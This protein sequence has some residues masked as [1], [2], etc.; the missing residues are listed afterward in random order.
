S[1]PNATGCV[2]LLLSGL[3]ADNRKY[4]PYMIKNALVNSSKQ[5]NENFS[6]GLLQ[7]EKAWEYLEKFYEIPDKDVVYEVKIS[8]TPRSKRGIYLRESHETSSPQTINV[9]IRPKFMK[10]LD[11]TSG[12]NNQKKFE[13]E[14]RLALISTQTWVRTTDFLFLGSTGRSFDVKVD[15]TNLS[16]GGF[17]FAEVQGYD[18]TCPERGPLFRVPITITKPSILTNGSKVCFNKLTFGP[19]H[20]E[21][22]FIKVPE[23]VTLKF[24]TNKTTSPALFWL[25]M[26]QLLPLRRFTH[27]EREYTLY[28][29]KGS[30]GDGSGNEQI[31]K[32]SFS[33]CGGLTMEICLAQFWSSIGNHDMSL[34]FVFHGI[35][36]SNS[37][38]SG[39][40]SVFINGGC[41]YTRLD[42]VAPVKREEGINPSIQFETIR[43]EIRPTESTLKPLGLDRDVLPDSRRVHALTLTYKFST[44]E[45]NLSVTPKFPAFFDLL[46]DSYFED[47]FAILY[48]ANKK[49]I[50]YLDIYAKTFKLEFKGDYIIRA[51]VRHQSQELLEKL[52]NTVC[53]LDYNLTKKINLD[54]YG[55]IHDVFTTEK[56]TGVKNYLEKGE[57]QAIYVASP[58]D[59]SVYPKD[60]KPG[61]LLI[62]RLNFVNS[63]IDGG[64]FEISLL[65][66]P[67]PNKSKDSSNG[68]GDDGKGP[69]PT[70]NSGPS[71]ST[72]KLEKK[73]EK[74]TDELSEAIRDL[75]IS[76]LKKFPAESTAKEDL[77]SEL[78]DHYPSHLPIFQTKLDL[79]LESPGSSGEKEGLSPETANKILII[80]DEL[81]KKIDLVE[82]AQY[83][84][85]KQDTNLNEAAKKKKKENDDKKKAVIL[86]LGSK[87]Q[88]LAILA[89]TGSSSDNLSTQLEETWKQLAQW[90][91]AVPP[92]TDF[93]Q[94]QIYLIR[95]KLEKRYGN[96]LKALGKWI[97]ET[98]LGNDNIKDYEK[99]LKLKIELLKEIE[100]KNWEKYEE[101]WKAIRIPPGGYAPF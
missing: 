48:D 74:I 66:P 18:T 43:K 73:D 81:L 71:G 68:G 3:K 37:A 56:P 98:G 79:L 35:Q 99:A 4:S 88:A 51:Q 2:A 70:S 57:R 91:D 12:E 77:F 14:S 85:V 100:W 8:D 53:F 31:E 86:A 63:K 44:P 22:K 97:G 34:E 25:H 39:S 6:I 90:L 101:K 16:P 64:Q 52:N 30:Y 96:A 33:V 65:I 95:E 5:I 45:K 23:D 94:L 21:R 7:V 92:I 17:Y 72:D 62:G 55:Q 80:S 59:Y 47:F 76:Y 93:K 82:L 9:F 60:S 61:D 27:Q 40:K 49:V 10:E 41:P 32:R 87:I 38:L 20:I 75:Q 24:A 36:I 69:T 28:F 78:E 15:P 29:A 11:P 83:Y 1:S 67:A 42:I 58:N 13:L 84:G 26:I 50:G 89:P 19:G 46:Y 54:V